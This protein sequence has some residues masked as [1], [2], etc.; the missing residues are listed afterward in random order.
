M[1]IPKTAGTALRHFVDYAFSTLPALLVYGERPGV[2]VPEAR[3][4]Y[5]ELA[6]SRELLFGHFDYAFA[7]DICR[8]EPR[9]VATIRPPRELVESYLNFER[10][11]AENFLDNPLVRHFCGDVKTLPFGA[12]TRAHLD[13]A[14]E[15][16]RRCLILRHD[17][18]QAFADE[19]TELFGLAPYRM[20]R[21]NETATT[22]LAW[23]KTLPVD[24]HYDE[25]FYGE[26]CERTRSLRDFLSG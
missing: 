19:V 1:H 26:C 9:I 17:R 22:A 13:L 6:R 18:L 16:A 3:T 23:T 2:S 15:R 4:T 14:L 25:V 11:P 24:V 5:R 21:V 10:T 12:I 8:G 7:S 20:S